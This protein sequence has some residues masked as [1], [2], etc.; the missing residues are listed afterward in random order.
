MEQKLEF[1][2]NGT[3]N[4]LSGTEIETN[5]IEWNDIETE[6]CKTLEI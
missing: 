1:N 3:K 6:T 5:F 4:A 2:R